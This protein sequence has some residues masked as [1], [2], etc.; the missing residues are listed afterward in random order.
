MKVMND[1]R[2]TL[3]KRREVLF[4][5]NHSHNPGLVYALKITAEHFE[6]PEENIAIKSVRGKFGRN[7][8]LINAFIYDSKNDRESFEPKIKV[9]KENK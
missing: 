3:L 1:F 7:T 6:A 9:K 8:F 4:M 2:N 5:V